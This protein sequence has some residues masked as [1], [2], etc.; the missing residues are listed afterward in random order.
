MKCTYCGYP[1]S[2]VLDS[3]P[4]EEG[5]VIRRR[6]ECMSCQ[7]RFTT[8][9]KVETMPLMV[10]KRDGR[11]QLFDIET[12][13]EKIEAVVYEEKAILIR[14]DHLIRNAKQRNITIN[15]SDRTDRS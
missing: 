5:T 12:E 14:I 1:E 4:T 15:Y 11:R 6:R 8:Y 7:R 10:I 2:K 3:R 9:E 13:P